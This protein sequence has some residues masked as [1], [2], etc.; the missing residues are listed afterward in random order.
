MT[1]E[2]GDLHG[3]APDNSSVAL[4]IIDMI[5]DFEF[6]GGQQLF[7]QALPVANRIA[8]LK[9]RIKNAGI[10]VIYVNDNFGKWRSDFRCQVQHCLEEDVVG[11]PIVQL[12]QPH[13]DD[14]YVLKPKHSAFYAT[15]IEVLLAYLKVRTLILTGVA[16]N[17]CVLLSASEAFIRDFHIVVPSDCIASMTTD[18]N[19]RAIHLLR[20]TLNAETTPSMIL[21]NILI[22][23]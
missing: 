23:N 13:P 2:N 18:E 19:E 9:Q 17:S 11:K 22:N 10:P 4:L 8:A 16:G 15:P 14:Y 12:L 1:D 7:E 6:P 3:N 21:G 5:N 20:Q